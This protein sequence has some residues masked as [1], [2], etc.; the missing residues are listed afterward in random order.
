MDRALQEYY[1]SR[2]ATMSTNGWEQFVEDA[3]AIKD[4]ITIEGLK[5]AEELWFAKGQLDILNWIL[6]I[7]EAS[8]KAYEDLSNA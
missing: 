3:R 8:E 2:F 1:E 7:K 4:T 6:S 5:S